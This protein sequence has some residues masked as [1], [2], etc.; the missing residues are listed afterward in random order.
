MSM[1]STTLLFSARGWSGLRPSSDGERR[2]GSRVWVDL[3]VDVLVDGFLHGARVMDASETGM[4]V[5][6]RGSLTR[7]PPRLIG[8]YDIHLQSGQILHV[9]ARNV[10]RRGA[11]QAARFVGLGELEVKTLGGLVDEALQ[12]GTSDVDRLELAERRDRASKLRHAA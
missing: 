2:V 7:R 1:M 11:L 9:L 10:W 8:T 6:L 3:P 4:V 12:R 5:E